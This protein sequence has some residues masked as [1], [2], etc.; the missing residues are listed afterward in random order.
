MLKYQTIP[1]TPFQQ[2]CSIVWDPDTK[3][4]AIIDPGG[5]VDTLLA[6]VERLGLELEQ[7]WITHAH[8]DH[9]GAAADI[10]ERLDLPVVGPHP[11]DQ[12]WIDAIGQQGAM[13]G[14]AG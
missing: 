10:A 8:I 14:F 4:A 13:F 11:A 2:N 5:D 1:V 7:V 3:R 12:F 6:E 9:A